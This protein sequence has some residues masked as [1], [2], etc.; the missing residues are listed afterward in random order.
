[1]IASLVAIASIAVAYYFYSLYPEIPGRIY[2][3]ARGLARVLENKYGFDTLY[4]GFASKVVVGGSEEV[5]WKGVD[6]RVIDGTVNGVA[7]LTAGLSRLVRVVQV[8][9]VRAYALLILGGA[10]AV[11]SY[12][13]WMHR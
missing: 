1:L 3:S 4:D 12:L 10:V 2:A 8:G 6:V 7:A 11:L 5:L 9:L 13:L